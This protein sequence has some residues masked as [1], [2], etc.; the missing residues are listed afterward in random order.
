MQVGLPERQGGEMVWWFDMDEI[1]WYLC[2]SLTVSHSF[3]YRVN[4][5][6]RMGRCRCKEFWACAVLRY[7]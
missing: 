5:W 3:A 7:I 2:P 1:D 6:K 4:V